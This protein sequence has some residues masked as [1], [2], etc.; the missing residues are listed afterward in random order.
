MSGKTPAPSKY[1]P[2]VR[3]LAGTLSVMKSLM[4]YQVSVLSEG[5]STLQT[6]VWSLLSVNSLMLGQTGAIPKSFTTL[7]AQ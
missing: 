1:F 7:I 5:L 4:Y 3:T 2:T 6:L